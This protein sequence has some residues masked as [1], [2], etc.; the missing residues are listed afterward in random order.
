MDKKKLQVLKGEKWVTIPGHRT[1]YGEKYAISNY[2]RL[3]KFLKQVSDGSLLKGSL[4]QGYPIWR[5]NKKGKYFHALLHRLVAKYFLPKPQRRETIV[6]HSNYKK[7]DNR[8]YNLQWATPEEASAHQQGSPAVKK[9]KKKMREN[10]GT[11]SATKLTIANVKKIRNLIAAG[12]TLKEI[13]RTFGVSDMQIHRI[14]TGENWGN[15][16]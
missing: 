10:P 9:A 3:A 16:K 12:K 11:G 14:K 6:I 4:Q 7:T 2:G 8:Y 5:T 1:A 13:A 15:L